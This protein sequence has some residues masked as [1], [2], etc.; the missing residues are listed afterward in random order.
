MTRRGRQSDEIK[1]LVEICTGSNVVLDSGS[2]GT[3]KLTTTGFASTY[4][5]HNAVST[6]VVGSR[7]AVKFTAPR[8]A[9][10]K[11][12]LATEI[13]TEMVGQSVTADWGVYVNTT[14][15][16]RSFYPRT[17]YNSS[18]VGTDT[19]PFTGIRVLPLLAGDVVYL[20][21]KI[22][23]GVSTVDIATDPFYYE[24][25]R[26]SDSRKLETI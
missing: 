18:S 13:S 8:T 2:T 14:S 15:N 7:K 5:T 3:G 10:Y 6:D 9:Y 24:I 17:F 4:S 12:I 25:T 20:A 26:I 23:A 21:Y 1:Q 19:T 11:F 16:Y 22:I